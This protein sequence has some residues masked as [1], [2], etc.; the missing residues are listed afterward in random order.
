MLIHIFQHVPFEGPGCIIDWANTHHHKVSFTKWYENPARP[1]MTAVDL[2]VVMG[3]PM[4]VND[5]TVHSWL[6]TEKE[7]IRQAIQAGKRVLGICLGA[8][9]IAT[10]LGARVYANTQKEIGWYPVAYS[11]ALLPPALAVE[12]PEA[13]T[14]FHWHG[15]TFDL[16]AG[17]TCFASTA[18]TPNQAF[19]IGHQVMGLQY[20]FEVTPDSLNEMVQH[21]MDELVPAAYVQDADTI[22]AEQRY[23]E[24]SNI[25][26]YRLLDFL[27]SN[28]A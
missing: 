28:Y 11:T 22:R 12:L 27:T 2:L 8:Q 25:T 18:V 4:S 17:A 15:D 20:H 6:K 14:V 19:L 26:M 7:C 3:G 9:L 23:L 13:Q 24:G 5:E 16:P 10:S 21:G 1:D